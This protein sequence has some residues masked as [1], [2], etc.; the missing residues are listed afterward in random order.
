ALAEMLEPFCFLNLIYAI[1]KA[2]DSPTYQNSV[3][4]EFKSPECQLS[5]PLPYLKPQQKCWG[6]LHLLLL[7]SN[8]GSWIASPV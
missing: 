6:F 2:A 4:W 8:V 1:S 7:R 3:C 5:P